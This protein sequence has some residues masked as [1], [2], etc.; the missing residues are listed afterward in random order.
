MLIASLS[1]AGIPPLSGFWSKDE[2]VT[3]TM[4]HPVFMV[5]TLL[6]A[7]MTAFYMF[8]L[9]FLTF[10]GTTRDQQ[11]YDHAHESPR[12]NDN[13]AA[14]SDGACRSAPDGWRFRGSKKDIRC[15]S[16]T[17]S[18]RTATPHYLIMLISSRRGAERHWS[19]IS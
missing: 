10:F 13:A 11:A 12:Y 2:I 19:G 6:V 1:I 18:R 14:D 17:M 3:A 5:L 9:I 4:G 15:S 16:T 8:R 7:F